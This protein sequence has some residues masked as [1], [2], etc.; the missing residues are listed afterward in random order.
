LQRKSFLK[1]IPDKTDKSQDKNKYFCSAIYLSHQLVYS[2]KCQSSCDGPSYLE[3]SPIKTDED[4]VKECMI[5]SFGASLG[6]MQLKFDFREKNV[7][8]LF[9]K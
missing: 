6:H 4:V 5:Y 2:S 7:E 3:N 9:K 1:F 8:I